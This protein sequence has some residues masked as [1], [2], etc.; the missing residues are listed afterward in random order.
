MAE[1]RIEVDGDGAQRRLRLQRGDDGS[2]WTDVVPWQPWTKEADE[3]DR[4]KPGKDEPDKFEQALSRSAA[5]QKS[6]Q[7]ADAVGAGQKLFASLPKGVQCEL[8]KAEAQGVVRHLVVMIAGSSAPA[9]SLLW[10]KM[11]QEV[12]PPFHALGKGL[13]SLL[14]CDAPQAPMPQVPIVQHLRVLLLFTSLA[15]DTRVRERA[16]ELA[17]ELRQVS[18][19]FAGVIELVIAASTSDTHLAANKPHAARTLAL[20]DGSGRVEVQESYGDAPS[21][22]ALLRHGTLTPNVDKPIHLLITFGHS[23]DA[24]SDEGQDDANATGG[25]FAAGLR[26]RFAGETDDHVVA[27]NTLRAWLAPRG[28]RVTLALNCRSHHVGEHLLEVCDHVI[29][30]H[31]KVDAGD[32][33][34]FAQALF[35]LLCSDTQLRDA[36]SQAQRVLRGKHWQVVHLARTLDQAPFLSSTNLAMRAYHR[37]VAGLD[38]LDL[39]FR[40]GGRASLLQVHVGLDIVEP[41]VVRTGEPSDGAG[42]PRGALGRREQDAMRHAGRRLTFAQLLREPDRLWLLRGDAGAG[43]TTTLRHAVLEQLTGRFVMYVHLP[44]WLSEQRPTNSTLDA[45]RDSLQRLTGVAKLPAAMQAAAKDPGLTL[46]LDSFDELHL[47]HDRTFVVGILDE[48]RSW[49][50]VQVIVTA[51]KTVDKESLGKGEWRLAE[52]DGLDA[53][54]RTDLLARWFDAKGVADPCRRAQA[55]SADLDRSSPRLRALAENPFFLT[56]LALLIADAERP[57]TALTQLDRGQHEL[58]RDMITSVLRGQYRRDQRRPRLLTDTDVVR[59]LLGRIAWHMLELPSRAAT[60]EQVKGWA[61]KFVDLPTLKRQCNGDLDDVLTALADECGVFR[62]DGRGHHAQWRF[63][64]NLLQEALCAEHWWHVELQEKKE[65]KRVVAHLHEQLRKQA[66][67]AAP[68]SRRAEGGGPDTSPLDFWTE[69]TALLAGWMQDDGLLVPL[70]ESDALRDLGLRVMAALDK[71][72]PATWERVLEV[73]P[74]WQF[75]LERAEL[76]EKGPRVLAYE[77][78]PERV[79]GTERQVVDV[80]RRR[81]GLT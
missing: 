80:L 26:F 33:A 74:L 76:G 71:I 64:H 35:P 1:L 31:P 18:D 6:G 62:P 69:P 3:P 47:G 29:A 36:V 70:L 17:H 24:E 53:D 27:A 81:A 12:D 55:W 52:L 78:L 8:S 45:V 10:Q 60:T 58:L 42:A 11:E 7:V 73:L 77:L 54:Q 57:L 68:Q 22:E 4:D 75:D 48:L 46:L 23:A 15:G 38:L 41:T 43:K 25:P 19:R 49:A 67:S 66:P 51:R 79:A 14:R 39:A 56:C 32:M 21:L 16:A 72:A 28:L 2:G 44:E 34:R 13:W 63:T 50:G 40:A 30:T 59:A 65:A 20:A 9:R 61:G 5:A 37:R